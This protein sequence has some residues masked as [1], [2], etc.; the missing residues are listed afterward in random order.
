MNDEIVIKELSTVEGI[1]EYRM[2]PNGLSIL[3]F[4]DQSSATATVNVTYKV[5]SRHEAY[6]ETGMAHLLEHM[7]FKG[8]SKMATQNW[9]EEQKLLKQLSDLYEK[10]RNETDT[11]KR[12]EIYKEI[13]KIS[14]EASNRFPCTH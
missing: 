7:V 2:E 1:T 13:D 14:Y 11:S 5:G 8:T 12:T 6:G 10:H 4:P 3:L 9:E